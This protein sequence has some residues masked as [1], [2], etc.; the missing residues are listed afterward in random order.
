MG[1]PKWRA[2][3]ERCVDKLEDKWVDKCE[4]K[5]VDKLEAFHL[6]GVLEPMLC[7]EHLQVVDMGLLSSTTTRLV[8]EI[9]AGCVGGPHALCC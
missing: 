4:D 7:V 5:R 3:N 6:S 1:G 9:D 8:V 2:C